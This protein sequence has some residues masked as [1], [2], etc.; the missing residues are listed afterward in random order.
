MTLDPYAFDYHTPSAEQIKKM[1]VLRAAAR[2]YAQ[3]LEEVL[4]D[5][6]DKTYLLRKL[7]EVAMWANV[8]VT[9]NPDGSPR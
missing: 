4:E 8:A 2:H 5:G 9:R 3:D 7:R 6:P 1:A